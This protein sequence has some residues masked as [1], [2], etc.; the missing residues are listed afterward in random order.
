MREL[1]CIVFEDGELIKA[2]VAHG[3]R[4]G[5]SM[6]SGQISSFEIERNPE[7]I[8]RMVITS[9]AGEKAI[10]PT[11]GPELAAAMIAYCIDRRVP[12]PAHSAKSITVID[13]LVALKITMRPD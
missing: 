10:V 12:V 13:G 3:Q 6:P 7:V 2:L 9:D 4:T 5:K 11:S 1:R 8:A